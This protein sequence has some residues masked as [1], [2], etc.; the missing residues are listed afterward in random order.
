VLVVGGGNS[1]FQI[2]EELAATRTVELSI[3]TTYPMPPNGVSVET[4]SDG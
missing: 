1:G 2:A 4:C 3:A